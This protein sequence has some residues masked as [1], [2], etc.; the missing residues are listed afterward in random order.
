MRA[1]AKMI[2][3]SEILIGSPGSDH[4]SIKTSSQNFE[5]WRNAEIEVHC[6][7]WIGWM[8]GSFRTGELG[9]FA[10]EIRILHRA[11]AGRA[12]LNPLEPNLI[13]TLIG[14]GKGHIA[15]EGEATNHFS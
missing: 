7:C 10:Q 13:L 3:N 14:D 15:V 11:L 12:E 2:Q 8:S 1:F 4:V 5:G 6:D 9:R